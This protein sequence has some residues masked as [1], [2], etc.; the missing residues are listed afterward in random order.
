[1]RYDDTVLGNTHNSDGTT[2]HAYRPY[3][4]QDVVFVHE[5]ITEHQHS[6]AHQTALS[7]WKSYR[8]QFGVALFDREEIDPNLRFGRHRRPNQKRYLARVAISVPDV[9]GNKVYTYI[10]DRPFDYQGRSSSARKKASEISAI[11]TFFSNKKNMLAEAQRH[12]QAVRLIEGCAY[13]HP[14]TVES[15]KRA[16]TD[17]HRAAIL[18]DY[19]ATKLHNLCD[20][21]RILPHEPENRAQRRGLIKKCND[22]ALEIRGLAQTKKQRKNAAMSIGSANIKMLSNGWIDRVPNDTSPILFIWGRYHV[23]TRTNDLSIKRRSE[24]CKYMREWRRVGHLHTPATQA[25]RRMQ[26]Q[27]I[28]NFNSMIA[29][30]SDIIGSGLS[31]TLPSRESKRI[32][33]EFSRR[34]YIKTNSTIPMC[35]ILCQDKEMRRLF[36]LAMHEI[37]CANPKTDVVSRATG[38]MDDVY[39]YERRPR[40][41]Q[42]LHDFHRSLQI[43]NAAKEISATF[44]GVFTLSATVRA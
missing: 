17:A 34:N 22:M 10:F 5:H 40:A 21:I 8:V 43:Q 11:G 1:M 20:K 30:H 28:R 27:A 6:L 7:A 13:A 15:V 14:D 37:M 36:L 31:I 24:F 39:E 18:K 42:W 33:E 16:F 35:K 44:D 2:S 3:V 25:L 4:E 32:F 26:L 29:N 12:E 38:L 41:V 9:F 23:A 19:N